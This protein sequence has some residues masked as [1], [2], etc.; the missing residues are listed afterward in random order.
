LAAQMDRAKRRDLSIFRLGWD[1]LIRCLALNDPISIM[2]L[3]NFYLMLG[4]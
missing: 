2:T 3:P 4:G 1:F